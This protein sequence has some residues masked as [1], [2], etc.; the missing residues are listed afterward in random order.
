MRSNVNG[1]ANDNARKDLR[2]ACSRDLLRPPCAGLELQCTLRCGTLE[3]HTTNLPHKHEAR[4]G[5]GAAALQ[6]VEFSSNFELCMTNSA[7]AT[8][9]VPMTTL[10]DDAWDDL[11]SFIEERRVIPIV[12]PELPRPYTLND[13]VCVFLAARGRRIASDA[14]SQLQAATPHGAAPQLRTVP[15]VRQWRERIQKAQG[16]AITQSGASRAGRSAG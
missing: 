3:R 9:T 13:V 7:A 8:A 10:D 14:V 4:S 11:L 6:A 12:G 5:D 1:I 15:D 16:G 2:L